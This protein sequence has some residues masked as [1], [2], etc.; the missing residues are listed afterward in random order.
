ML[1]GAIV[2]AWNGRRLQAR[3]VRAGGFTEAKRRVFLDSLAGCCN[4]T[5]S[6]KAAG[7]SVNTIN[8]HRRRDP[9][10]AEQ[11]GEALAA[12]YLVLEA[13]LM[14]RAARGAG[15][16]PAWAA[17]DGATPAAKSPTPEAIDTEL[18]LNLMKMRKSLPGSRTGDCGPRPRRASA[19]ELDAA[20]L[21]KL[22]L[23]D[24]RVK[25]KQVPR[26]RSGRSG[27]RA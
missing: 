1:D 27:E 24:R 10:F 18:A 11:W 23:L 4:V 9:V 5:T 25:R 20:I 2:T 13:I 22:A 26:L 14:E 17:A 16:D 6:A 12:G 7:V 3:K 15:F 8:Y 19:D 21:A